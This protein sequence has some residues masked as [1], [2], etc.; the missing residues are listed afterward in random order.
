MRLR[1]LFKRLPATLIL[2]AACTAGRDQPGQ[3]I[4]R[5]AT[6]VSS[7]F[8]LTTPVTVTSYGEHRSPSLAYGSGKLLAFWRDDH[9]HRMLAAFLRPSDGTVLQWLVIPRDLAVSGFDPTA[10]VW[11]GKNFLV[12]WTTGS[13]LVAPPV[14]AARPMLAAG[15]VL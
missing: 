10:V 3:P 13:R 2:L 8:E 14:G 15:F 1:A 7:E 12:P 11:D 9:E 5:A 6:A 4:S